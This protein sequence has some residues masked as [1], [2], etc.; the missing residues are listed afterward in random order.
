MARVIENKKQN[1]G[2]KITPSPPPTHFVQNLSTRDVVGRQTYGKKDHLRL[3]RT[4]V[5]VVWRFA[6]SRL[7]LRT[8]LSNRIKNFMGAEAKPERRKISGVMWPSASPYP[9]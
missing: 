4:Q 1:L 5:N 9:T 6:L 7:R 2:S 8:L 3:R